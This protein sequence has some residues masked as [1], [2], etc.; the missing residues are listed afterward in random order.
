MIQ[1]NQ[2]KT[3]ATLIGVQRLSSRPFKSQIDLHLS[4]SVIPLSPSVKSLGVVLDNTYVVNETAHLSPHSILLLSTPTNISHQT[5]PLSRCCC[6][7][8]HLTHSIHSLQRMQTALLVLSSRRRRLT[9]SLHSSRPYIGFQ[10]KN[11]LRT[12]L[13]LS[14]TSACTTLLNNTSL[15]VFTDMNRQERYAPPLTVTFLYKVPRAKRSSAG[16]RA[17]TYTGPTSRNSLLPSLRQTA[18]PDSFKRNLK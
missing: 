18:S 5:P 16:Q 17:F 13:A 7:T 8:G 15:L 10:L 9:T 4:S 12:R 6:R 14:P 2:E 11:Q 3:E 1:L